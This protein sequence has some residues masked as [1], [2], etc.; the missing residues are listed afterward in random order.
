[1]RFLVLWILRSH[2]LH[3]MEPHSSNVSYRLPSVHEKGEK[4]HVDLTAANKASPT[5]RKASDCQAVLA[6]SSLHRRC[7]ICEDFAYSKHFGVMSCRAC[8]AFFRRTIS[9][10]RKYT[11]IHSDECQITSDKNLRHTCRFC[12]FQKCVQKGMNVN[13]ISDREPDELRAFSDPL[14]AIVLACRATFVNRYASQLKS[15]GGN[16]N[17]VRMGKDN[18]VFANMITVMSEFPVVVDY[19]RTS[20]FT[21]YGLDSMEITELSKATFYPWIC[22]NSVINT[23]RNNGHKLKLSYFVDESFVKADEETIRAFVRTQPGLL[24][25]DC[26]AKITLECCAENLESAHRFSKIRIDEFEQ[27]ILFHV[28]ALITANRMFPRH[29]NLKPELNRLFNELKFH[30]LR[31]YD[32][33]ATRYGKSSLNAL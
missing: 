18:P 26:A 9:L 6:S 1:M 29:I 22:F 27:A 25:Y 32:D 23:L 21:S 7:A 12:R 24:D 28:Y 2:C 33:L 4:M 20:G 3:R 19:L 8:A 15:C 14:R 17:N 10:K 30:Y 31:N 13:A 11:C 5:K 16:H